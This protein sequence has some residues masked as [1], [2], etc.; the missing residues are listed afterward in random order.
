MPSEEL[1]SGFEPAA[2]ASS[3]L[4]GLNPQQQ[5]AVSYDG[6]T[7]LIVA[8][9]GSGKTRVLTHRIAYQLAN[10]K[11]WPSQILA[12]TFT[13]KA[14][15][16]MRDRVELLLGGVAEGMWVRTFHS[17]CLQIL[18]REAE[19]LGYDKNFTIY[20][21]GDSR[22]LIKRLMREREIDDSQLKPKR[23][24]ELI[25]AAKSELRD[26][27]DFARNGPS[28]DPNHQIAS[29][30]FRA[31]ESE[32]RRN[33]ALDFD[34]LITETVQLW[35][36]YPE[37]LANYQRRFRHVLVD[38]YQD[39]NRAQ[40]ELIR[41]LTKPIADT[42]AAAHPETGEIPTPAALTVV[43]DSDQS[44]YSFRG[45]D[46]RNM[47]EFERDFPGAM[48][49]LLEQN[50]RSTQH[51]LSAANA[52][53][54]QNA[55]RNSK[56]LWSELGSGE[57][58][59]IATLRD[60]RAEAAFIADRITHLRETGVALREI[61]V[62]FRIAALSRSLEQELR[63]QQI[64]YSV[65]GGLKFFERKEIK[66]ALSYL[67]AIVNPRDDEALRRILNSPARG[68]GQ[69]TELKLAELARREGVSFRSALGSA[70]RLQLGPKLS[71]AIERLVATLS[72]LE[73]LAA[74]SGPGT[75][76]REALRQ[77]GYRQALEITR[78]P[79]DEARIENLDA[80]LGQA[81]EWEQQNPDASVAD[82]LSETALVSAV[83]EL[84][85]ESG[86]V[87]LMTLH[88]A[89][90]LEYPVVFLMGMEQGILP[91]VRAFNEP[92]GVAEERRLLYVGMT[93][94]KAELYL[95]AALQRTV[96]GNTTSFQPSDFLSAIPS[97]SAEY[98]GVRAEQRSYS[99]PANLVQ[100]R[101]EFAGKRREASPIRD[102]GDL[103]LEVGQRIQHDSYGVGSVIAV[104]GASPRQTAEIRFDTGELKKLLVKLAPITV[105]Q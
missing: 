57:P 82:Y 89:K 36:N 18:R 104:A 98:L 25:S 59:R 43:G 45:A 55:Y 91:Y 24:A 33:N 16:E 56:N 31:Y 79:Q 62:F 87:S 93:R 101:S 65:I 61:A 99:P 75:V 7:L 72:D 22:A 85:D 54:A 103:Q 6:T 32:L 44:I 64:P 9:A 27:D 35:R 95:S 3:L 38:E 52:V 86:S 29:E 46:A 10:R 53:I 76:L 13:N 28:S 100:A 90:G 60:E 8:G 34:D 84:E 12:I 4:D 83:D 78:D 40:Y 47:N 23:I 21:S 69:K 70:G 94:A 50:Y 74:T 37:V 39:T 96:F 19:R 26:A 68:I 97:E 73:D 67:S 63:S 80:L 41:L 92:E 2:T 49:V 15:G 11:V 105:L 5:H 48:V 42:A 14:A 51:I 81:L 30:I 88:T 1:R 102:N 17:A 71:N 77:T 66:D 58:V 20:D